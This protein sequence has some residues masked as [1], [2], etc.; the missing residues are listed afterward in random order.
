MDEKNVMETHSVDTIVLIHGL[1]LTSGSWEPWV[2]RYEARGFKVMAPAY[3]GMEGGVQALRDNPEPIAQQSVEQVVDHYAEIISG[4]PTPPILIGHSFG[5][6]VVQVL[7]DRG[8]GAAGVAI[9]SA[10]VRGVLRVPLS[11]VRSLFHVLKNPANRHRAVP[12]S[13]ETFHYVFTNTLS[14]DE[15]RAVYDRYAIPSPGGIVFQGAAINLDSHTAAKVDFNKPDRAPLLFIAGGKDHIMP[16]SLNHANAK[17]YKSG[18]VAFREFP[19]RDHFTAG[20]KGW[21]EVADA[22]LDWA[23]NPKPSELH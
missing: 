19:A 10:A 1:W 12:I 5:G 16:A 7:L 11:Q 23:M 14:D 4:L 6:T 13:P 21:E 20:E 18:I 15:S 9:D 8:L 17:K 2:K 22:A 3:P